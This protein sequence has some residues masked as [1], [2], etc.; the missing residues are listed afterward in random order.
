MTFGYVVHSILEAYIGVF[1]EAKLTEHGE[2]TDGQIKIM[3]K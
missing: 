1:T 3:A 2:D